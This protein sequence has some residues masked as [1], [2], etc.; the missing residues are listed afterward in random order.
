MNY[1]LLIA[2]ILVIIMISLD[3]LTTTLRL[4]GGGFVSNGISKF[5]WKI[6]FFAGSGNGRSQLLQYA[7][8]TILVMLFII[9]SFFL[10]MGYSLIFLSSYGSVVDTSTELPENWIGTI[11]YVGYT[12]S[13]LGIGDVKTGS[14]TWRIVSNIMSINGLFFLS[15]AIS[16]YIPVLGAVIKQRTLA[17]QVWQM[18]TN[19]SEILRNG[20]NG[21]NFG[22]LYQQ[23]QNMESLILQHVQNHL[24]YPII[25]YFHSTLPKYSSRRNLV[26]LDEAITI[27]RV[28]E[29]E[30]PDKVVYW[31]SIRKSLDSYVAESRSLFNPGTPEAPD[32]DYHN[33]L[34]LKGLNVP[35][36]DRQ[37]LAQLDE[38][39]SVL[40]EIARNDGW[41][42]DDIIHGPD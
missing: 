11:Y 13:S 30:K 29:L 37:E 32:F 24:A 19:P 40:K 7:G 5:I 3:I 31:D 15:L 14:D 8:V 12:V 38:R 25:G 16:Y 41:S 18:G 9:W 36:P 20:W 33:H 22:I 21:E 6:F 23:F 10:W 4:E 28:L 26:V 34:E 17:S 35:S 2:G 1:F 42:W 27:A 39:R